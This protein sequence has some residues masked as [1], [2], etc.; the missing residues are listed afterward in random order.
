MG[1]TANFAINQYTVTVGSTAGGSTD[2]DGSH[3]INHGDTLTITASPDTGYHFT[4]WSGDA[5]GTANPLT[6]T[7]TSNTA[8]TANFAINQ[9]TVTGT[10]GA[11]GSIAVTGA[12]TVTYGSDLAFT[13]TPAAGY[14]VD[15]W[16]V[17]GTVVQTGGTAY[18]LSNIQAAHTTNVTFRATTFTVTC[19]A[20]PG[21]SI[22]PAGATAV[23]RGNDLTLTASP[24]A[25]YIILAWSVDGT[26]VQRGGTSFTLSDIFADHT[27]EVVFAQLQYTIT[28]SAG[29]HGIVSPLE[30]DV[31]DGG[32]HKFTATP[33]I[34][35][36]VGSWFL[37]GTETQF[38]GTTYEVGP[39][40]SD[41]MIYVIFEKTLSYSLGTLDFD[42]EQ[43]YEDSVVS[44]NEDLPDEAL[45]LI[46][47]VG[48]GQDPD[49]LAMVLHSQ[50]DQEGKAVNARAKG[51]F[52]KTG[53]DEVLIRFKYLFT[54]S[55]VELVV[56]LSDSPLLMAH[57]DPLRE[58]HY[59]EAARLAAPPYPRPGSPESERFAVFQKIVWTG[60]LDFAEGLYIELELVERIAN[61]IL[62]ASLTPRVRDGL[63]GNSVYVDN[64]STEVQCYGICLDINWDNFVDEADFLTVIGAYGCD[65]TGNKACLE[66]AF[67]AD[68]YVDSYDVASW[69]WAMNS[70][71]RLLNYCG[72]PLAGESIGIQMMSAPSLAPQ[73][74]GDIRILADV[75]ADLGDLL[76]VGKRGPA[77]PAE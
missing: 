46:E 24:G 28:A 1:I 11:N 16:S 38:G 36:Q 9:Y 14:Q 71:Q 53:A 54:T 44:N 58:Q 19:L 34:G 56:Y 55:N 7:V 60:G 47:A 45:V 50:R 40:H 57:G 59:I 41:H 39:V 72:L 13:A 15:E 65:A 74:S 49:N 5:S 63:G 73:S 37:D 64:W 77:S 48:L 2:Q 27:V 42:D 30:T 29:P 25:G 33:A 51:T 26:E 8:I 52:I 12:T 66:G 32:N 68:G 76:V 69:D 35:Y 21:G 17:D 22:A 70:D 20:T 31:H 61:G 23:N 67:S 75:P 4:G 62:L 18:T 43:E 6:V 10:S 3:T